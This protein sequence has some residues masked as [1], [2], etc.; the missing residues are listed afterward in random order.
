ML[1]PGRSKLSSCGCT[2]RSVQAYKARL[3]GVERPGG[4]RVLSRAGGVTMTS[5][6]LGV[7]GEGEGERLRPREKLDG[8]RELALEGKVGDVASG[9]G[10]GRAV[11]RSSREDRSSSSSSSRPYSSESES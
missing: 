8:K 7:V 10:G 4:E 3:A 2:L 5:L 11:F 6:K 9:S 1:L